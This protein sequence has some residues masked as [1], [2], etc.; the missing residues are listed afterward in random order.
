MMYVCN[1]RNP[2]PSKVNPTHLSNSGIV[3]SVC[4][5][6]VK[7]CVSAL[8]STQLSASSHTLTEGVNSAKEGG[9]EIGRGRN[10]GMEK[11]GERDRERQTVVRSEEHT[12]AL[13]SR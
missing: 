3:S 7:E 12:S 10:G 9:G 11:E 5:S 8:L 2:Y 6:C 13:Q 4:A 1:S